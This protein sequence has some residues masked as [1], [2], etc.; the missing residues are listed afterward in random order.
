[1]NRISIKYFSLN[2]HIEQPIE[3][4]LSLHYNCFSLQIRPDEEL[5]W[6][7]IEHRGS[8]HPL[9]GRPYCF[10][11]GCGKISLGLMQQVWRTLPRGA[12]DLQ[13]TALQIRYRGC[14]G[15]VSLDPSLPGRALVLRKSML[16]FQC[17]SPRKLEVIK[18][19]APMVMCLN[20]PLICLLEHHGIGVEVFVR[21]QL[22]MILQLA[23]SLV[24]ET[25]ALRTLT[26]LVRTRVPFAGL[27]AAGW[28]LARDPFTIKVLYDVLKN[29]LINL[30]DKANVAIPVN[31]A[32]NMLGVVDETGLLD[33]GEVFIQFTELPYND[34]SSNDSSHK[35]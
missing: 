11:D 29:A 16:K 6:N 24:C 28:Q 33:Y 8:V 20:R 22:N 12:S 18:W 10:S 1:M 34:V 23:D 5:L 2:F 3:A 26:S 25:A 21:L 19:S 9:S 15:M 35:G 7:D 32:R 17:D 13:P 4:C 30:K 14:K 27:A 31:E